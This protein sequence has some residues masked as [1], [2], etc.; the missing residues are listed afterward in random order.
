MKWTSNFLDLAKIIDR[1]LGLLLAVEAF[2]YIF[3]GW[4]ESHFIDQQFFF[5]HWGG[6]LEMDLAPMLMYPCF[7]LLGL[8]G[9]ALY[10]ERWKNWALAISLL[11]WGLIFWVDKT[12]YL[13]H[14][15]FLF[16]VLLI[17][18]IVD[19]LAGKSSESF[20]NVPPWMPSLWLMIGLV[21][22]F[23]GIAKLNF[24]WWN[25]GEPLGQWLQSRH[26][27]HGIPQLLLNKET[28]IFLARST[29]LFEIIFPFLMFFRR[30][31]FPALGVMT[32][33]HLLNAYLWNIGIFPFLMILLLAIYLPQQKLLLQA[34]RSQLHSMPKG[35]SG[36]L[37][38][39]FAL[40][41]LLPLR[42]HF[43]PGNVLWTEEGHRYAW[44]MKLRGKSVAL[45]MFIHE[46]DNSIRQVDWSRGL[47]PRQI[48][49]VSK[50]PDMMLDWLQDRWMNK[51]LVAP[52]AAELYIVSHWNINQHQG[53]DYYKSPLRASD[54]GLSPSGIL[55]SKP[56]RIR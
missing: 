8:A 2:R 52:R 31:K 16:L 35:L 46:G 9:L 27:S 49:A 36:G 48:M 25:H 29:A 37:A 20:S 42:H 30:V 23:A 24:D 5:P 12:H 45:R 43:I 6:V 38:V 15:Y 39:F 51:E 33:F 55:Q 32:L 7:I 21:Y 11:G 47:S 54:L 13:N 26:G 56:D 3:L 22:I 1:G 53:K 44:R 19:L 10:L 34:L 17:R 50:Q 28:I 41:I 40:Q 18:L 4:V 14:F